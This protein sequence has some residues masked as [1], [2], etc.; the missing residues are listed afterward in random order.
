MNSSSSIKIAW[1]QEPKRGFTINIWQDR[2]D[3]WIILFEIRHIL[4]I[5]NWLKFIYQ[6]FIE[7][8][9]LL[10]LF[11]RIISCHF[12]FIFHCANWP[13]LAWFIFTVNILFWRFS[14]QFNWDIGVTYLLF[15]WT[16]FRAEWKFLF[17]FILHVHCCYF[18]IIIRFLL[19]IAALPIKLNKFFNLTLNCL[20]ICKI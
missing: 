5:I 9:Y 1:F 7:H 10:F 19:L 17:L 18:R 15:A 3:K 8:L 2:G 20:V 4:K 14:S 13:W 12:H 16:F 11:Q 6:V